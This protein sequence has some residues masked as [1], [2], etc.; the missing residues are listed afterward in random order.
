MARNLRRSR[1]ASRNATARAG[2]RFPARF[3]RHLFPHN[4]FC[5]CHLRSPLARGSGFRVDARRSR[6]AGAASNRPRWSRPPPINGKPLE[7]RGRKATR[8]QRAP[9]SP[10]SSGRRR[11]TSHAS[12]G[13]LAVRAP[14]SS[15]PQSVIF[16]CSRGSLPVR[17]EQKHAHFLRTV[18]HVA[19]R[20]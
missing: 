8:L 18:D 7:R 15:C 4:P 12:S 6:H 10:C 11:G 16:L 5:T 2:C 17:T 9:C 20:V 1:R 13:R 14:P 3:L 19:G